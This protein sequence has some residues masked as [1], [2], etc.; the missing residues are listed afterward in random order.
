MVKVI[1]DAFI[2][3]IPFFYNFNSLIIVIN[4]DFIFN[5]ILCFIITIYDIVNLFTI[6]IDIVIANIILIFHILVFY[7]LCFIILVIVF[8]N[9]SFFWSFTRQIYRFSSWRIN[10][11]YFPTL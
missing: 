2:F 5:S 11:P 4:I 8:L 7:L 6:D 3:I 9:K 1:F 10:V